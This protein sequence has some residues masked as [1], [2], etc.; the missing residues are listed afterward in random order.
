MGRDLALT[1]GNRYN[2][3]ALVFFGPY[4]LF[5]FP[6]VLFVRVLGVRRLLAGIC[7]GWGAITLGMGFVT[8]WRELAGLRVLLGAFEAASFSICVYLL[9]S[10]YTRCMCE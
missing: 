4:V 2:V 6:A 5:E 7:I 8:N 1:V 9:S 3:V 10:W